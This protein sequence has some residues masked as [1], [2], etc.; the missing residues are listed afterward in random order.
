MPGERTMT[1]EGKHETYKGYHIAADALLDPIVGEGLELNP[2]YRPLALVSWQ[3]EDGTHEKRVEGQ[4]K[5]IFV[6]PDDARKVALG[7]AKRYID[8]LCGDGA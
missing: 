7:L 8:E 5:H 6:D 4:P 1:K 3:R 2:V